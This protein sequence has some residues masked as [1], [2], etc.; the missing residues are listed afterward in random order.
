[1][2]SAAA[3]REYF[4]GTVSTFVDSLTDHLVPTVSADTASQSSPEPDQ[5]EEEQEEEEEDPEDVS[6][7][8][9][10]RIFERI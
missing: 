6:Y 9:L 4:S 1:M 5:E 8:D 2:P 10:M 7:T 3:L